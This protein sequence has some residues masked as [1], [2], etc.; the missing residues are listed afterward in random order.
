VVI[1]L[2]DFDYGMKSGI[3]K[4][5]FDKDTKEL[6]ELGDILEHVKIAEGATN[7]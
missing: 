5:Y 7:Q 1:I 6:K 2:R 4:K 3:I